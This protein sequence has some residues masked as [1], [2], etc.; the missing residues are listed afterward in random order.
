MDFFFLRTGALVF[1]RSYMIHGQRST[2]R[3]TERGVPQRE[4]TR[5]EELEFPLDV[6]FVVGC[7]G[8]PFDVCDQVSVVPVKRKKRKK[9]MVGR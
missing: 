3:E 4:L 6:D 2:P 9:R 1:V 5:V 7:L 8:Q